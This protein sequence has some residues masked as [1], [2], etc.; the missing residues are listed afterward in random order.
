MMSIASL[1][2]SYVS[3]SPSVL[4]PWL[5]LATVMYIAICWSWTYLKIFFYAKAVEGSKAQKEPERLRHVKHMVT[6]FIYK[7][8]FWGQ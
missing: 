6:F 4:L 2:A 3:S 7:K 8:Y 5:D 1:R